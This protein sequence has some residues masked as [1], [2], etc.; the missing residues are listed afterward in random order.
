MKYILG[1]TL[2]CITL[3]SQGQFYYKDLVTV[4]ETNAQWAVL[5]ANG[6]KT[7]TARSYEAN[8]QP[9]EGFNVQQSISGNTMVTIT[10]TQTSKPS[11]FTARYSEAGRLVNTVDTSED[12][13]AS[14]DY[15]YDAAGRITTITSNSR[16]N[17]FISKEVHLWSYD[18]AG[19]PVQML[20]IR[21]N[22]DTTVVTFIYDGKDQPVEEHSVRKGNKEP[23]TYYYY[24]EKNQLTDIVRYNVKARRLLPTHVFAYNAQGRLGAMLLVPEGTNQYQRWYYDYDER[25]LRVRERLYNKQQELDGKVEFI[26][27]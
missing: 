9:S 18:A 11:E 5:K 22:T 4:K 25:G 12:Y 1:L 14:T 2:I 3:V 20:R 15:E 19:K 13:F 6:I 10:Q 7:I 24:N 21:N 8:N 23:E 17:E 26:Y 27:E 16:S